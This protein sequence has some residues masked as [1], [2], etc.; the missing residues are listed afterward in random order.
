MKSR[1]VLFFAVAVAM[2]FVLPAVLGAVTVTVVDQ[3]GDLITGGFY[4]LLEED[5]TNV[6]VP[7]ALVSDSIGVDIHASHAPVVKQGEAVG[8]SA[9]ISTNPLQ[10]YFISVLPLDGY[11]NSGGVIEKNQNDVTIVVRNEP[12]PTAQISVLVFEDHGPINNA[13]DANETLL[14]DFTVIVSDIAGQ[15]LLDVFGNQLGTVY[16]SNPDG[17]IILDAEGLPIVETV[18]DGI[19]KTDVNGEA[20][21]KYLAPG[22]YGIEIIPPDGTDWIQ[23]STIEGTP[24][25]DAWV[26]ANEPEVFVEGFGT[27]FKHAAFGFVSPSNLPWA[28]DPPTSTGTIQGRLVYNHFS[29]PPFLQGYFSGEVVPDGMVGL[30]DPVTSAGLVAVSCDADGYFYIPNVPPGTYELVTWDEALDSLFGFNQVVVPQ[31]GGVVDLNDV[32]AFSWFGRLKGNVFIDQDL[33]GYRDIA[34]EGISDQAVLLRFRDG[35]IYQE[36]VTVP[37]G[38]YEFLE[39]FPFFKWLITEVD[40]ISY[41]ATGATFAVDQGGE[42]PVSDGWDTPS[43][44]ALNPQPQVAVNPNTGNN[45]SRTETGE[46]LTQAMH[47]FLGQTNVIDWGK[48]PY[49]AGENGGISGIVYYATTR[50]EDDPRYAAADPWEPGIPRVQ[51]NLYLDQDLDDQIDDLDGNGI[52]LADVDNY[53]FGWADG[54]PKGIEDID[55]N[56]PGQTE[57]MFDPGDAIQITYT[58]SWD[59]SE[60]TDCVQDIPVVHGQPVPECFDNFGTWNQLRPGVFD[61]GFAFASYFP[62]GIASGSTEVDGLPK[63]YYI[64]E[65]ATP[66]GYDLV[67]EEDKNVDFGDSFSPPVELLPPACVGDMRVV[68]DFLSLFPGVDT[69]YAGQT[70]PLCNRKVVR[71]SEGLNAAAEFFFFTKA[72]KAARVVGFVNN[73]LAAEFDSTS[74]VYGEKSAPAWLPVSFQDYL[75]NEIVRVY[76][77]EF[78][79]Y[80]ALLPSAFTNNLPIPSGMSP[81]MISACLN[82]PF[83][84]DPNNPGAVIPDPWYDPDFSQACWIF[85]YLPGMTTYLD[86]PIV[87]VAASAGYKKAQVDAEPVDGTPV[88][89]SVEGPSGGPIVCSAGELI[90]ITSVGQKLVPNPDYDFSIPNSQKTEIRD[91]GFGNVRG[92]VMIGHKV[93]EPS[94]VKWNPNGSVIKFLLPSGVLTGDITIIRGDNGLQTPYG[95]TLQVGDCGPNIHYVSEGQSIQNAIDTA[96]PCDT[97]IIGPGTYNEA[98]ILYK[99]ITLQGSG[100]ESTVINGYPYP[101]AQLTSW[102]QSIQ[103]RAAQGYFPLP[104]G[105]NAKEHPALFVSAA[106]GVFNGSC[107]A[108]VDGLTFTG[109]LAGGGIYIDSNVNALEISNNIVRGNQGANGA[110]ITVGTPDTVSSNRSL[111]IHDNVIVKNGSRTGGGG[112]SLYT[113]SD[114]YKVSNN[115]IVGNMSSNLGGGILHRGYSPNGLIQ[116]NIISFNEVFFGGQIGGDGGGIAISG[117]ETPGN[118]LAPSDGTG[119]VTIDKNVLQ[120][121]IAGAGSGGAIFATD[122]NG[123]LDAGN[124]QAEWFTLSVFNNKIVNNVA[125][126]FG[127]GISLRNVASV[128]II[129]NTVANNDSI[130]TA[131]ISFAANA[132]DSTPQP[133]GVVSARNSQF[134][135]DFFGQEYPNP[136]L[137]DNIITNNRSFY[138]D[139][140][141]NSNAGGLAPNPSDPIWDLGVV[142]T[143][144][145]AWLNPMN[146]VLSDTTGYDISNLSVDPLFNGM[147]FNTLDSAAVL[148]EGG[149]FIT[150]RMKP[151]KPHFGDY[152][153]SEVSPVID[154]ATG[155]YLSLYPELQSDIDGQTRVQCTPAADIGADEVYAS[156]VGT[157]IQI[158]AQANVSVVPSGSIRRVNIGITITNNGPECSGAIKVTQIIP[159]GAKW[160]RRTLPGVVIEQRGNTITYTLSSLDSGGSNVLKSAVWVNLQQGES[161]D[162]VHF[163]ESSWPTDVNLSNNESVVTTTGN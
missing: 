142:E 138:W 154:G 3:N 158:D 137:E 146:C 56:Y 134:F 159:A 69:A 63:G 44:G 27:G 39:V 85:H 98:I 139:S 62:G 147:Y 79:A 16:Q 13:Y 28:M 161:V 101:T 150:V 20:L 94:Q 21:I 35:T 15:L 93:I 74:P 5:N 73:D 43:F 36:T 140:S 95:V 136:L 17:S 71:V 76:T 162:H 97:I 53:P 124:T 38:S 18:G 125:A 111:Y 47:L 57:G 153:L 155:N 60:P 72:P 105:L 82:H 10:R 123:L 86:T 11:S 130:A 30:N 88:I 131:A 22:K 132:M 7:G 135:V 112:I 66:F 115:F 32:L 148:D 109:S 31:G 34:E 75:G 163:L 51:L 81:Q 29:R 113:G 151:L 14:A 104:V 19:V 55:H 46:V 70:R 127:A 67:K 145:P 50:A 83:M 129:H 110:G 68:P 133:S 156:V 78:G 54:G 23:T 77:D 89:F 65:A 41:K 96:Q 2:V 128:N 90:T 143:V 58:D 160:V 87:P 120:G 8:A 92:T 24:V 121:N 61:G 26:Q 45:L 33:D 149:N 103:E 12:L 84:Q 6:T 141:L 100:A 48:A 25:I 157:D 59:D 91:Y 116:E 52:Q 107:P 4:W 64:V 80:N 117:S 118:A 152:G 122:M 144:V 106:A 1:Y 114:D 9:L 42:I 102:T 40:F 37:D 119:N 49:G 99:K 108:R 126:Y